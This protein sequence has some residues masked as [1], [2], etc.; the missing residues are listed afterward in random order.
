M[1]VLFKSRGLCQKLEGLIGRLRRHFARCKLIHDL[2]EQ[3]PIFAI[4]F[5]G[6]CRRV[7]IFLKTSL[8]E[9]VIVNAPVLAIPAGDVAPRVEER[10]VFAQKIRTTTGRGRLRLSTRPLR[11]SSAALCWRW[12]R[13][14]CKCGLQDVLDRLLRSSL[15]LWGSLLPRGLLWRGRRFRRWIFLGSDQRCGA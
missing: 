8:E 14:N 9:C 7:Q 12:F 15:L 3:S 5:G 6:G 1:C 10:N 2:S 4:G 13:W 11:R